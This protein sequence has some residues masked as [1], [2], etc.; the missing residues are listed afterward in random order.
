MFRGRLKGQIPVDDNS[1]AEKSR[2]GDRLANRFCLDLD[3]LAEE[4]AGVIEHTVQVIHVLR[5]VR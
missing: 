3:S 2:Q 1:F 4:E 5:S